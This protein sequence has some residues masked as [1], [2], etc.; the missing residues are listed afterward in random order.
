VA[1]LQA[2]FREVC[3]RNEL[4]HERG[5]KQIDHLEAQLKALG[6]VC[7]QNESL[8]ERGRNQIDRLEA[9]LK[10]LQH[11]FDELRQRRSVRAALS[12]SAVLKKIIH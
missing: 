11:E 10:A 3:D 5:R 12:A 9:Q 2:L 7:D 6:E 1:E 8:H 4:F